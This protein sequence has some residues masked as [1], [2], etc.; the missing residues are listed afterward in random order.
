MALFVVRERSKQTGLAVLTLQLLIT[1]HVAP[2]YQ[3]PS[4]NKVSIS[5]LPALFSFNV[6]GLGKFWPDSGHFIVPKGTDKHTQCSI[7]YL[8]TRHSTITAILYSSMTQKWL[9]KQH[10]THTRKNTHSQFPSFESLAIKLLC[11][12]KCHESKCVMVELL[13]VTSWFLGF[14]LLIMH[15]LAC[16]EEKGHAYLLV[17]IVRWQL[18][19]Q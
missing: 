3:F 15:S 4:V 19:G 6:F 10:T 16:L 1:V 5:N 8:L 17:L 18:V 12:S 2:R 9:T 11:C 14:I 7:F 13:C